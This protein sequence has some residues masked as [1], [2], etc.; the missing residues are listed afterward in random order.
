[1]DRSIESQT[2]MPNGARRLGDLARERIKEEARQTLGSTTEFMLNT[3]DYSRTERLWPAEPAVFDTNP[4][5]VA[6]GACGPAL[7]LNSPATP[8]ELPDRAVRWILDSP[9]S[10]DSYPPGLYLGL[11]GMA[12][13]LFRLGLPERGIE[14]MRLACRSPLLF[15]E[16]GFLLGAAGWGQAALHFYRGTGNDLW[17]QWAVRAGEYLLRTAR[18]DGDT[19]YWIRNDDGRVHYGFG[20]GASGIAM[21]LCGLQASTG[22]EAFGS[23]AS[24]AVA[25]D[26]KHQSDSGLC[27][28]WQ[29]FEGDTLEMPYLVHGSAGIGSALL[30]CHAATGEAHYL[31][32]AYRIAQGSFVKFAA[33]PGLF[34]G[35]TGIAEFMLDMHRFTGEGQYLDQALDMAES[36]G[37][38]AIRTDEGVAWPG[39]WLDNIS[40]DYAAGAAGIGLFFARL[41]N[42]G[43]RLFLDLPPGSGS[44]P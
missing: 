20:H 1:M 25:F 18:H 34:E 6:H 27:C 40:N 19:C 5:S 7:Y 26:L 24:K 15:D 39:K 13:T 14:V 17:L 11:A 31:T 32:T 22:T 35:L 38:F 3:A 29:R 33:A 41:L 10:T 12:C 8:G 9:V 4:L 16:P 44:G 2:L 36:V 43:E 23:A 42:P 28:A 21:F 37:W 30:R